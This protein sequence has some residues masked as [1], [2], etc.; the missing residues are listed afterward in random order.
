MKHLKVPAGSV[1]YCKSFFDSFETSNYASLESP[2]R[3]ADSNYF[4]FD[5]V[6][7]RYNLTRIT[8]SNVLP[9]VEHL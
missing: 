9:E 8:S 2:F 6:N 1:A 5:E 3:K 7:K 4:S